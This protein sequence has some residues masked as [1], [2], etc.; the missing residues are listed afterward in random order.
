MLL[1]PRWIASF[2]I[3]ATVFIVSGWWE[4][5]VVIIFVPECRRMIERGHGGADNDDGRSRNYLFFDSKFPLS[6][7]WLLVAL[8]EVPLLYLRRCCWCRCS[9]VVVVVV[10]VVS[11]CGADSCAPLS[12]GTYVVAGVVILPRR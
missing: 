8:A 5:V 7:P 9:I 4:V 6:F 2:K 12:L 3:L 10:I 11:S 1:L